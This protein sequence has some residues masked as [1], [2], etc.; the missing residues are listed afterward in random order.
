VL[1]K[2]EIITVR[3]GRRAVVA[4]HA[5]STPPR[6]N[7]PRDASHDC[8]KAGCKPH[9]CR[10][11]SPKTIRNIHAILS[12]AFSCAVRWEWIDRNP[13]AS[14]KPP[15]A[16]YRPPSSPSPA[17]VG[18]VITAAR[19]SGPELV[20]LYLWLAA[21][22][23][24]RRGELCAL[25]WAD[26][27]LEARARVAVAG[28]C[29]ARSRVRRLVPG[30]PGRAGAPLTPAVPSPGRQRATRR[31]PARARAARPARGLP[32]RL[33]RSVPPR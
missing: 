26:I 19:E 20:A 32:S 12:G 31:R 1:A 6:R 7:R 28:G 14:A 21:I 13:A 22:T 2:E 18:A 27:D 16:R 10:P 15:R 30:S 3:Q 17:D 24:A 33:P 5:G 8:A 9:R 25:R 4:G 29:P 23:G 11:M